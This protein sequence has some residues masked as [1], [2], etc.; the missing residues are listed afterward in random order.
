M[1]DPRDV[2]TSEMRRAVLEARRE[3]RRLSNPSAATGA[4]AGA[5]LE[6]AEAKH[7]M[8]AREYATHRITKG[9]GPD[10][11]VLADETFAEVLYAMTGRGRFAKRIKKAK[12]SC[13][14]RDTMT[15]MLASAGG[16]AEILGALTAS[17]APRD[18]FDQHTPLRRRI[19]QW[20]E[21]AASDP[22]ID[23]RLRE[24]SAYLA[25]FSAAIG[26]TTSLLDDMRMKYERRNNGADRVFIKPGDSEKLEVVAVCAWAALAEA[27]PDDASKVCA[28]LAAAELAA[29]RLDHAAKEINRELSRFFGE[30]IP[31]LFTLMSSLPRERRRE[32][33]GGVKPTAALAARLVEAAEITDFVADTGL[34]LGFERKT[35]P[36]RFRALATHRGYKPIREAVVGRK[37]QDATTVVVRRPTTHGAQEA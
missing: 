29:A 27:F 20:A 24:A 31:R 22:F 3:L 34:K 23:Q 32:L 9:A 1:G 25:D 8:L 21:Q 2:S 17:A 14:A 35:L 26:E 36:K 28:K 30:L 10:N 7:S 15:A 33:T 6:A 12:P 18:A 11:E 37:V 13:L 5:A 19:R 4:A 16:L